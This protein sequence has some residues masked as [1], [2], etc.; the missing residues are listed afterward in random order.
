[1]NATVEVGVEKLKLW[2]VIYSKGDAY[3]SKSVG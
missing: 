3:A 2:S 1:M